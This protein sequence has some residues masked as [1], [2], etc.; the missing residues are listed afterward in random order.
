MVDGIT[1]VLIDKMHLLCQ[2]IYPHNDSI[3]ILYEKL[4]ARKDKFKEKFVKMLVSDKNYISKNQFLYVFTD[5][6][7]R[8]LLNPEHFRKAILADKSKKLC[9]EQNVVEVE[10]FGRV[11]ETSARDFADFDHNIPLSSEDEG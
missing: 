11:E 2:K 1:F 8:K 3:E 7:A 6:Y 10:K 4:I 5:P 9:K